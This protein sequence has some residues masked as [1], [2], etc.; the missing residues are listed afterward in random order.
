VQSAVVKEEAEL[1]TTPT[2]GIAQIIFRLDR[3]GVGFVELVKCL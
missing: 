3:I 1:D 2:V